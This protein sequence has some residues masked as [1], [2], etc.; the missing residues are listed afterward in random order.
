M[1]TKA[2]SDAIHQRIPK[3]RRQQMG[4]SRKAAAY[5]QLLWFF[6]LGFNFEISLSSVYRSRPNGYWYCRRDIRVSRCIGYSWFLVLDFGL[7]LLES[8][9]AYLSWLFAISRR[10]ALRNVRR[11]PR[12]LSHEMSV[13]HC[14]QYFDRPCPFSLFFQSLRAFLLSL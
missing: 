10:P 14:I 2:I 8:F 3:F 9:S 7:C 4:K 5:E 12:L 11:I 1:S 13:L 6:F